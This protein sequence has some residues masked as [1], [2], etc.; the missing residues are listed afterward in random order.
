MVRVYDTFMFTGTP[1][2]LDML[3]CRLVELET[4]PVYRHVIV[5]ADITHRGDPKPLVFPEHA[6]RFGRWA[7]RITYIPVSASD[8]P[9][10]ADAPDPWVREHAQREHAWAGVTSARPGDVVLHGDLDEIPA[11]TAVWQVADSPPP[12]PVVFEQAHYMYAVDWLYP[13]RVWPG[14]IAATVRDV[15][16]FRDLRAQ[17]WE[18][19]RLPYAG[20]HLSWMGGLD[21]QRRKLGLHCHLEMT[22]AEYQRIDSGAAYQR[23]AHHGGAQMI[24]VEVD[25]TWPW[26]IAQRRCPPSWFRPR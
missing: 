15:A 2:E 24:P 14:T 16:G 6:E 9:S 19:P 13:G 10:V 7:D 23:G 11:T 8:L 12:S 21:E 3:Q 5:E 4:A 22:P 25:G 1:V 26:W 20:W 18:L 17:R